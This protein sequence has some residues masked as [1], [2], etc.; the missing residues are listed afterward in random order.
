MDPL[1]DP[2]IRELGL[3]LARTTSE[4]AEALAHHQRALDV[5]TEGYSHNGI[6]TVLFEQGEYADDADGRLIRDAQAG[7]ERR[8]DA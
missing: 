7:A 6:G 2:N 4:R 5:Y 8:D 3:G 1:L